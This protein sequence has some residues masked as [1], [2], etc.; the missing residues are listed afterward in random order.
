MI[1]IEYII[2]F[3]FLGVLFGTAGLVISKL[4]A[5]SQRQKEAMDAVAKALQSKSRQRIADTVILY[6]DQIPQKVQEALKVRQDELLIEE[7]DLTLEEK[8]NKL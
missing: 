4:N 1:I 2:I 5:S 8:I 3:L 7:D 6:G